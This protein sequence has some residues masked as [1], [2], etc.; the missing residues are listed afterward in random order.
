M[1]GGLIQIDEPAEN[2][3]P[4]LQ[5]YDTYRLIFILIIL[6]AANKMFF[7]SYFINGLTNWYGDA[8]YAPIEMDFL[9]LLMTSP[10]TSCLLF[11]L[12]VS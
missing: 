8:P 7:L 11:P 3:H 4:T 5:L 6:H 10:I 9:P 2:Y 1:T 12:P